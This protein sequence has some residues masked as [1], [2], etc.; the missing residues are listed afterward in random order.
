MPVSDCAAH[1]LKKSR[2]VVVAVDH[3]TERAW[4]EIPK[5]MWSG[6]LAKVVTALNEAGAKRIGLDF[7]ISADPDSYLSSKGIDETPNA[8]LDRAILETDGRTLLGT[9]EAGD[10]TPP[11]DAPE[12]LVSVN[13]LREET[14]VVRQVARY[15]DMFVPPLPGL[16]KA[17][18][19]ESEVRLDPIDINY[20]G[21][22]PLIVSARDVIEG[23]TPGDLFR[24]AIVLVGETY[25]GSADDHE[26]PFASGVPGVAV[27]AEAVRTLLDGNELGVVPTWGASFVSAV[28]ALLCSKLACRV[29]VGRYF[30]F[31]GSAA[32]IWS[33]A[34]YGAFARLNAVMPWLVPIAVSLVLVPGTLYAVRAM[35]E[36]RER[37]WARA[38]WG[39][40]VGDSTLSRLE[41]NRK[42]GLGS[43]EEFECC[44]LFLDI[45]DFTRL[46]AEMKS[47]AETV[48]L[49][50]KVFDVVIAEVTAQGGEILN[51]IGDGLVAK[52]EVLSGASRREAEEH[53]LA[54]ALGTLRAVDNLSAGGSLGK[55][56]VNIRIGLSAGK[57]TLALIGSQDRR[58]MT[59]YGAA[60]NL[61]ARLE[62]AGKDEKIQSRLVV[63]DDYA[64]AARDSGHMF[65]AVNFHP[66]GWEL[67][68]RVWRLNEGS[69]SGS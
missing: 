47:G 21:R 40:L 28:V 67:P 59:V 8:D 30:L 38:A 65:D 60:V 45:A 12:R 43:W 53:A 49:L 18:A 31:V 14:G 27:N 26:T 36:N 35:E 51:F 69:E 39:Q 7:V 46:S 2:V 56:K 23:R 50:N 41:T 29:W 63:S 4:R 44:V 3:E 24:G 10:V 37:L 68:L 54:A 5:A 17:I 57:A 9:A 22:P 66:R 6:E 61:A 20:S 34:C 25:S 19:G 48:E 16:A 1:C 33:L 15:D 64:E 52:W 58:Q 42:S 11:L 13:R 55:T 32:V 62:A